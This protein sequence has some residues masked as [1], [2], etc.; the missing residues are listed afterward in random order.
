MK[1]KFKLKHCQKVLEELRVWNGDLEKYLEKPEVPA[2]TDGLAVQDLVLR[3][4]AKRCNIVR[5]SM[6]SFHRAL[7][8]HIPGCACRSPH[9]VT[10]QLDWSACEAD[11][12][13]S[14]A[15]FQVSSGSPALSANCWRKLHVVPQV[16]TDTEH[17]LQPAPR[18]P[19]QLPVGSGP[20]GRTPSPSPPRTP[21]PLSSILSR[22]SRIRLKIPFSYTPVAVADPQIEVVT[23][24]QAPVKIYNICDYIRD[25]DN[26]GSLHGYIRDPGTAGGNERRF[27]LKDASE[28]QTSESMTRSLSLKLLLN[29]G[30]RKFLPALTRKH[31]YGI[32][33]ALCWSV[34]HLSGSPWLE[35]ELD[36][37][38][39]MLLYTTLRSRH[40]LS[41][42]PSLSCRLPE[43]KRPGSPARGER[44]PR[45][46]PNKTAKLIYSLGVALIELCIDNPFDT[47]PPSPYDQ[48][49]LLGGRAIPEDC[50]REL[51][52]SVRAKGGDPYGDAVERCVTFVFQGAESKRD[53]E[54]PDFRRVF[55]STVVAPVQAT[56]QMMPE[57][58]DRY[59]D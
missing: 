20:R 34:L 49:P 35:K 31:R 42:H 1:R 13:V 44:T 43:P 2:T 33:V 22:I 28:N 50:M 39:A 57:M 19:Q 9:Q 38:R 45:R 51:V 24:A 32:A 17:Q 23:N 27:V 36:A 11:S 53:F 46:A 10:V 48:T 40:T 29:S 3:F 21:S 54:N 52:E 37:E 47:P 30:G 18:S 4:N 55:Y 8:Y 14:R 41:R 59:D 6:K 15:A 25:R 5:E 58:G 26:I 16:I 7:S 56:Y 12:G